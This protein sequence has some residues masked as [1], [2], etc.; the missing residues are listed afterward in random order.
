MGPGVPRRAAQPR[1]VGHL[2]AADRQGHARWGA[3]WSGADRRAARRLAAWRHLPGAL[4]AADHGDRRPRPIAAG[5][6]RLGAA[7]LRRRLEARAI[8]RSIAGSTSTASRRRRSARSATARWA[9]RAHRATRTSIWSLS[10][11]FAVGGP[12]Y[13]RV[14]GRGVQRRSTIP[15][16]GPPARDISVPNTFGV[17]R[18]TISSPRVD[19]AGAEVLLLAARI[20]R[21]MR[22]VDV[23]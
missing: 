12:R 5:R 6:A 23:G 22:R 13:A 2:R 17:I 8:S 16:F 11:R 3:D 14:P 15:S 21:A 7:E 10:K 1:A 20:S 4:R 19:R 18:N 9:S